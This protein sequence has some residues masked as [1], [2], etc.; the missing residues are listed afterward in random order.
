MGGSLLRPLAVDAPLPLPID[1]RHIGC[2]QEGP[3]VSGGD[4][5]IE[6]E[7]EIGGVI[8]GQGG[9]KLFPA[10]GTLRQ[11]G[12]QAPAVVALEDHL[13]AHGESRPAGQ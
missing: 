2:G 9:A 5:Q 10:E 6:P 1:R 8:T 7:T 13:A 12:Q 3:D 4:Q 11:G